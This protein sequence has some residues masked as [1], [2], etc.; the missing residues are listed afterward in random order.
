MGKVVINIG[1]VANDGTG[2]AIRTGLEKVN[3]MLAEIYAAL[4]IPSVKF[5]FPDGGEPP[6]LWDRLTFNEGYGYSDL[7][8]KHDGGSITLS[9]AVLAQ[10][11]EISLA[12]SSLLS[13]SGLSN[14]TGLTNLFCNNNS[15]TELPTLPAGLTNLLCNNNSLTELPTLPAGLTNLTCNNNSLTEL[16]TLPAG[17]TILTCYNN[18]LTELPT[19]PAGLTNLTCYNNS[20]TELPTLPAGLTILTCNNNSLTELPTLPA[21]INIISCFSNSLTTQSLDDAI[22]N[23]DVNGLSGG[24]FACIPQITEA[25]PTSSSAEYLSLIAKD[26]YIGVAD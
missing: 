7:I 3:A 8:R 22:E 18:S 26:W 14:C 11:T 13:I 19:L 1:T 24:Y 12:T 10:I 5:T 4:L 17:L 20:L 21:V 15:L 6:G 9:G 16:P 2:E 23:L 25:E